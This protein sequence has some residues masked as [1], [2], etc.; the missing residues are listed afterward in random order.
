[1]V[2]SDGGISVL[3]HCLS[4]S[5]FV[6]THLSHSRQWFNIHLFRSI[7]PRTRWVVSGVGAELVLKQSVICKVHL[8]LK[9]QMWFL[10]QTASK[11]QDLWTNSSCSRLISWLCRL[12]ILYTI[13]FHRQKT[14]AKRRN[15]KRL[16]IL[17]S[18]IA[19]TL[20]VQY[21]EVT[22]VSCSNST[23][24]QWVSGRG[25]RQLHNRS[26]FVVSWWQSQ[27]ESIDYHWL[28]P[29]SLNSQ[30]RH[31]ASQRYLLPL[32]KQRAAVHKQKALFFLRQ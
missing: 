32:S 24:D 10:T 15:K 19:C 1:M 4:W 16:Y 27:C 2:S 23:A 20:I 7:W 29:S 5:K 22:A 21:T 12:L 11:S 26:V 30:S 31:S 14:V 8:K 17:W 13:L 6:N 9:L 25:C 28:I 3:N 18:C